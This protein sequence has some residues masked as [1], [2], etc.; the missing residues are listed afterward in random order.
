MN[1]E[2]EAATVVSVTRCADYEAGRVEA[3]LEGNL[4]GLGGMEK[5]VCPGE[6]VLLKPNFIAA[7]DREKAV[8]TDPAVLLAVALGG[9]GGGGGSSPSSVVTESVPS[10]N[11]SVL[12]LTNSRRSPSPLSAN[13]TS[14][15]MSNMKSR[16]AVIDSP[17]GLGRANWIVVGT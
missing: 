16:V 9:G 13:S 3:A 12:V 14:D 4:S 10:G 8:Q 11:K 17:S 15:W 6:R 2:T 7:K 1:Q 5:F